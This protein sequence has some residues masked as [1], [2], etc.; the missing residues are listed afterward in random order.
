MCAADRHGDGVRPVGV[1]R[2]LAMLAS[3]ISRAAARRHDTPWSP[4]LG[5]GPRTVVRPLR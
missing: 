5:P 3:G 2:S 1:G 4:D